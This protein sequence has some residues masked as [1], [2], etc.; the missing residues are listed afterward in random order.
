MRRDMPGHVP[1]L[2]PGGSPL[3]VAVRSLGWRAAQ[4][5][6]LSPWM[7]SV[8]SVVGVGVLVVRGLR[9]QPVL[10]IFAGVVMG[11][12]AAILSALYPQAGVLQPGLVVLQGAA[13]AHFWGMMRPRPR[14]TWYRALV[15][16]PGSW[17]WA[18]AFLALPWAVGAALGFEVWAPW[19][20]WAVAALG[21]FRSV[22]N[23]QGEVDIT[24]DGGFAPDLGP[25][26]A[27]EGAAPG[28]RPLRVVQI[29]D[30][31]LGP[32]MS[33]DRLR[34]ICERAV[35][36]QPD[37]ILLTGDYLTL[38][39]N[40]SRGMLGRALAP[41][42]AM[43]GRVF[44]CLGNHDLEALDEVRRGLAAAG[45][46]LLEDQAALVQTEAGP[47]Q[48]VG[49]AFRWRDRADAMARVFAQHP[50]PPGAWRVVLLHDPFAFAQL[51]VGEGELVLSGHTHGGQLG[52]VSLGLRWTVLRA[53]G[54]PDHGL[55]ARGPDRLYIHRG[56]GHYGFPL[57]L[58]VPG[59]EGLL[60]V[61]RP[62]PALP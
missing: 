33:E 20:P 17:G 43:E 27:G 6:R 12:Q 4:E 60:R 57:R 5:V 51:P 13:F 59:E 29:T 10:G 50:R 9:I 36:R 40:P 44:A 16:V 45:V 23:P 32:F 2:G 31:H 54:M 38:E 55:W 25:W 41:L 62:T 47:V 53:F 21:V 37:L 58:G 11:L 8:L 35:A 18:G 28:G 34:R 1:R 3:R 24:L 14:P 42:R 15:T 48:V 49:M 39:T 61:H 19:L 7:F 26:P 56:T 46:Q 22:V 30:P 52:L